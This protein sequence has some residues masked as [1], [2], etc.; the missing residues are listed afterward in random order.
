M[1]SSLSC[2]SSLSPSSSSFSSS[3][4]SSFS[5]SSPSVASSPSSLVY[6][7]C[8]CRCRRRCCCRCRC[9]VVSAAVAVVVV[10]SVAVVHGQRSCGR[11]RGGG[12]CVRLPVAARRRVGLSPVTVFVCHAS[13]P[14][15]GVAPPNDGELPHVRPSLEPRASILIL[16]G[17]RVPSSG[18]LRPR[19]RDHSRLR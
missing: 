13:R 8:R 5:S 2:A 9:G 15:R 16:R 3:S 17:G 18:S 19:V 6:L 11:C 14:I 12:G 4:P 10:V 7:S 1:T